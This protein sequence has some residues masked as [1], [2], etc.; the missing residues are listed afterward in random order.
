MESKMSA[1]LEIC[2]TKQQSL[3]I[4]RTL[5]EA[6]DSMQVLL[7]TLHRENARWS[8]PETDALL[9][10]DS[11]EIAALQHMVDALAKLQKEQGWDVSASADATNASRG[12]A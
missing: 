4:R 7:M 10:M 11:A 9:E 1:E 2:L 3:F 6:I 12:V 5:M 8:S